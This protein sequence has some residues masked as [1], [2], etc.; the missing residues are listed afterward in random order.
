M[1]VVNKKTGIHPGIHQRGKSLSMEQKIRLA[2]AKSCHHR[3]A[4]VSI[5]EPPE[6]EEDHGDEQ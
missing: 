3:K 5:A 1:P 6:W 2:Q 4:K